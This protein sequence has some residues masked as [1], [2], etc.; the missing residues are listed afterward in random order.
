[1]ITGSTIAV[2]HHVATGPTPT[3]IRDLINDTG[4]SEKQLY[5][6]VD[7][8]TVTGDV[9][10]TR[11]V[12]NRKELQPGNGRLMTAY[13][14]LIA[15]VGHVNWGNLL[16]P[17]LLR[18]AWFLDTPT[19]IRTIADRLDV[20]P[21]AVYT[22]M[23]PLTGRAMLNPSGPEYALTDDL[24]PLHAVA[25]AAAWHTHR[26][27]VETLASSAVIEWYDPVHGLVRPQTPDDTT[28][29]DG[30]DDWHVTGLTAFTDYD[31]QFFT[32][33]EPLFWYSEHGPPAPEEIACHAILS[34][35]GP[36]H[37]S[38][39]MLLIDTLDLDHDAMTQHA[40]KYDLEPVVDAMLTALTQDDW[41]PQGKL[42][43]PREYE[44]LK[45]QYGVA[46][47]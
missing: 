39:A 22:A 9:T 37:V 33:H 16:T 42:P 40:A 36:R 30:A 43:G 18:V 19:R 20:T 31:L 14:R 7:A 1:M 47:A 24:R 12:N 4:Y 21:Q 8:L 44:Q 26:V 10:E 28:V 25:D 29:F 17:T 23:D 2:L 5:R 41:T 27:C 11:G 3:T 15:T 46:D 45:H 34:D 32:H 13:K 38:Y 6:A 35:P